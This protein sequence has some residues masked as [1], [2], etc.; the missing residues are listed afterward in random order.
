MTRDETRR[1]TD[2]QI[3]RLPDVVAGTFFYSVAR[4]AI[5]QLYPG[6]VN[7]KQYTIT[8]GKIMYRKRLLL[9][10][11]LL[12][13]ALLLAACAPETEQSRPAAT[14]P[15]VA[16]AQAA[17]GPAET[18]PETAEAQTPAEVARSF[19]DWYLGYIG[20]RSEEDFRNPLQDGAYKDSPYLSAGFVAQVEAAAN[21]SEGLTYDPFLQAQDIPVRIQVDE[22]SSGESEATIVVQRYWG[23][24]P[25]PSPMTVHLVQQGGRWL[26]SGVD[27]AEAAEEPTAAKTPD[28]AALAFYNW[29]L[30]YIGDP[31]KGNFRNPMVDRIYRESIHLTAGFVEAM[32]DLLAGWKSEY[33]GFLHDPFLCAQDVPTEVAVESVFYNGQMANV[34]VSTS[35]ENHS[36][37]LDV[38]EDQGAWRIA[39]ITCA[40]SAVG[41]TKAFYT[42][43]LS[44]IGGQNGADRRNPLV[45]GAFRQSPYL[46][47]AFIAQVDGSLASSDQGGFD[48]I[49][50]AQDVPQGFTVEPGR[51]ENEVLVTFM[52]F[53]EDGQPYG[54]WRLAVTTEDTFRHPIMAIDRAAEET[55]D[56]STGQADQAIFGSVGY[57]FSFAHPADWVLQEM[58]HQGP[59]MPDDWPVVAGWQ[60]MPDEIAEQLAAQGG[61][62]D[63]NAPPLV[64]PLQ[65][66]LLRGDMAA[67]DRAFGPL[68]GQEQ[69]L[70]G[71][72]VT[73]LWREPG[74]RHILIAHPNQADTW[75]IIS[76]WVTEFPG[77]EISGQQVAPALDQLLSS[78]AFET[79]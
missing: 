33:G 58:V 70:A 46:T 52:F 45:D 31:A 32:D 49:L 25:E 28:E 41:T 66:E 71:R 38:Q 11:F 76:D 79:P 67:L 43:Y 4:L 40:N 62:P 24:N 69:Q 1:W 37:T 57:G 44:Y 23:G 2:G 35:F 19:Y 51:S 77:R 59:G 72:E 13:L 36:I 55:G 75:L 29:Y 3:D 60:M 21:G 18:T 64:A 78:L 74:Y 42:W 16:P 30:A 54:Q 65:I 12:V 61:P 34:L 6:Q 53:G 48:P 27:V 26:I 10:G 47:E 5:K 50:L 9:L 15:S 7:L 56:A 8:G 63:P 68:D 39:G 14:E 17:T 73:V 20:D 22:M